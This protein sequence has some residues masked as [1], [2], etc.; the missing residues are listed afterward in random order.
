MTWQQ[1][2]REPTTGGHSQRPL[3]TTTPIPPRRL[4]LADVSTRP[5]QTHRGHPPRAA[6]D[7]T[8]REQPVRLA[9]AH[10][11]YRQSLNCPKTF[12]HA[13]FALLEQA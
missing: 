1:D 10:H 12:L 7:R 8:G 3:P 13:A 4:D 6:L 9:A 11:R 5:H 2:V